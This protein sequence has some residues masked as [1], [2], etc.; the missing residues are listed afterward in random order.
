MGWD[1]RPECASVK[2]PD[3]RDAEPVGPDYWCNVYFDALINT[4]DAGPGLDKSGGVMYAQCVIWS[5]EAFVR[6]VGCEPII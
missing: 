6:C 4:C 5:W 3:L 2:P 1:P